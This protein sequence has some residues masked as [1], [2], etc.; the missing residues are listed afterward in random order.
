MKNVFQSLASK[1]S[2]DPFKFF[3]Q[4][5][6]AKVAQLEKSLYKLIDSATIVDECGQAVFLISGTVSRNNQKLKFRNKEGIVFQTIKENNKLFHPNEI[7]LEGEINGVFRWIKIEKEWRLVSNFNDWYVKKHKRKYYLLSCNRI[8][9]EISK[10]KDVDTYRDKKAIFDI[11][12]SD[13]DNPLLIMLFAIAVAFR[14]L[15]SKSQQ[16]ERFKMEHG[17]GLSGG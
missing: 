9:A 2:N 14:V 15:P 8:I 12:Y 11:R 10:N 7:I 5:T 6:S 13:K 3:E 4:I 1:L 16:M 17:L